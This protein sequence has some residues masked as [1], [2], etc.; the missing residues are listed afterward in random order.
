MAFARLY[1]AMEQF[2]GGVAEADPK[3][4]ETL[5]A[6]V[7]ALLEHPDFRQ[8]VHLKG[9]RKPVQNQAH[10]CLQS[11]NFGNWSMMM[12]AFLY[13]S[14]ESASPAYSVHE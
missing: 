4:T 1:Q 2:E 5:D 14:M 11:N 9:K 3:V 12:P 6:L 7:V 10:H 8:C 13:G